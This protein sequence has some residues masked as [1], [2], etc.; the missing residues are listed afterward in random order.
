[1]PAL[2]AFQGIVRGKGGW[3]TFIRTPRGREEA[4]ACG[5]LATEVSGRERRRPKGG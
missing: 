5:Q 4:A 3:P 1:M 2:L